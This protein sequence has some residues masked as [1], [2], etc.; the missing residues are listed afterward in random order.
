MSRE[1]KA[2]IAVAI[3]VIAAYFF[4]VSFDFGPPPRQK[5]MTQQMS[6]IE[7]RVEHSLDRLQIAAPAGAKETESSDAPQSRSDEDT[8]N[9]PKSHVLAKQEHGRWIVAGDVMI[10][11]ENIQSGTT[12]G[13]FAMARF[14]EVQ[15]WD[16][17]H[18]PVKIE[19]ESRKNRVEK[20]LRTF[21]KFTPIRFTPY[22]GEQ[23]F[24]TMRSVDQDVCQSYLGKKGGE[25]EILLHSSCSSGQIIHELMHALGFVHEHSRADRDQYIQIHWDN[26]FVPQKNQFQKLDEKISQPASYPFDYYSVLLYP[27]HAFSKNNSPTIT[28]LDGTIYQANRSYLSRGDIEKVKSIYSSRIN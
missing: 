24:I 22:D 20:A 5:T 28:K 10:D 1:T 11:S 14:P 15:F 27:P 2:T 9:S 25:Q 23:D 19:V 16:S 3:I 17:V 12:E 4:I 7:S 21:E 13:D 26:I 18:V 8:Y 6:Q